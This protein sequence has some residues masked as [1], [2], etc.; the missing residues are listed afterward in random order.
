MK[1]TKLKKKY[2]DTYSML[3]TMQED[4]MKPLL[5]EVKIKE[6]LYDRLKKALSIK[7][8]HFK[9]MNAVIRLPAM[10]DQFQKALKRRESAEVSRRHEKESIQLLREQDVTEA[11]QDKFFEKFIYNLDEIA[12]QTKQGIINIKSFKKDNGAIPDGFSH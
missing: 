10:V 3:K 4:V 5:H 11:T 12:L 9:M 7:D 8:Q 6:E 1:I 2:S